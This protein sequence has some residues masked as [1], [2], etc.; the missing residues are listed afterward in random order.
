MKLEVLRFSSQVDS[1]SGILFDVSDNKR[2][3]LC[4]TLEDESRE[5]K[6]MHETRIPAGTYKLELRT[7]GGF[8]SR[9]SKKY[10][11][12]KGMIWVKDVP[13]FEYI[14]WHTGNTDE[15]TSGCLIV[16]Q[17]QHSNLI[18]PDGFVGSSVSAYK[19]IYP[20]VV[21]AI[22]NGGATVEYI[23]YD[24]TPPKKKPKPY[25]RHWGL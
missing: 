4:Y 14:L 20:I 17:Q 7:E 5:T 25:T 9:Y 16:G 1:T 19:H 11:W 15:H 13:G 10:S 6:V 3:F 22:E 8:H 12:Q 21:E 18:K 24:T 2:K 23:D